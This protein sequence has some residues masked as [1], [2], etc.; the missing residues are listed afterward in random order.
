V[1]L[2]S[3]ALRDSRAHF[4]LLL[5][6]KKDAGDQITDSC[7]AATEQSLFVFILALLNLRLGQV[8]E[9]LSP[10]ETVHHEYPE[11][12]RLSVEGA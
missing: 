12:Q 2:T 5:Q 11:V 3:P 10:T 6:S 4:T 7:P 8:R 9:A 1:F